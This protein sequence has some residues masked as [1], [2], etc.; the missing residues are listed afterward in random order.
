MKRLRPL[1]PIF[2][3]T[4]AVVFTILGLAV[5]ILQPAAAQDFPDHAVKI[6]VPYPPG[7]GVDGLARAVADRLTRMWSQS[8]IIVNKSGAAT[9]IGGESVAHAPPDGY[10]LLLTS[11]SSITSNPF[12]FLSMP[13]DPVKEL[14]PVTQLIDLHQMVVVH[15]SVPVNSMQELVAYAK[16][17]PGKLNYGSYGNGS[18]PNLLFETL[19]AQT[20]AQIMQIP[21][22]GIAPAI[23][24]TLGNEVQMTLGGEA[25]TG[26][27]TNAG[28]L[29]AL[30]I[31]SNE[32]LKSFPDVQTLAEAGFPDADPRSWFGV[33]APAGTPP[34]VVVKISHDIATLLREPEFKE[35]FI[36]SIGYTGVGSSAEE[37]TAFIKSDLVYKKNMI[38]KAG[39][40]AE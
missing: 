13:Y 37:F 36:D 38:E 12:L 15:P 23:T 27:Y 34:D 21:F 19:H 40:K 7:G 26:A 22:R 9:M 14:T 25:T 6:V 28:K 39:I 1:T 33:F 2:W 3:V 20:G 32:R 30:A 17:N 8:V 16:A 31:G 29:K 11:D 35:R 5:A 18:Q 4:R 24:A 10:T